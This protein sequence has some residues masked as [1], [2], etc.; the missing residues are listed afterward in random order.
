MYL[1]G[2]LLSLCFDYMTTLD[3]LF[4]YNLPK[5]ENANEII[6]K[7]NNINESN[8]N[9]LDSEY[10]NYIVNKNIRQKICLICII[11]RY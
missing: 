2:K 11:D 7:T 1:K 5:E 9:N 6:I 4:L 3:D 10:L 8:D